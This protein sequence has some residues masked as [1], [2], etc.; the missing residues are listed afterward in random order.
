MKTN[1]KYDIIRAKIEKKELR[2]VVIMKQ[3]LGLRTVLSL[4]IGVVIGFIC[5]LFGEGTAFLVNSIIVA[6]ICAVISNQLFQ[7][8]NL[9]VLIN[10]V[11]FIV[12]FF[13][14][15]SILGWSNYNSLIIWAIL[16]FG[17]FVVI[18]FV[19][20]LLYSSKDDGN[21]K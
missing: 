11:V 16:Y 20:S 7:S 4:F 21:N 5:T 12:I 18:T 9:R 10:I 2:S 17:P 19:A 13:V 1:K 15:G 3:N 6:L 8:S 14:Y